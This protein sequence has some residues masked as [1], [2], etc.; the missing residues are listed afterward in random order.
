M[1][2]LLISRRAKR[3]GEIHDFLGKDDVTWLVLPSHYGRR[4]GQTWGTRSSAGIVRVLLPEAHRLFASVDLLA[5]P[6]SIL[7]GF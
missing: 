7:A 4:A 5:H 2:R 6:L 1:Y 3:R